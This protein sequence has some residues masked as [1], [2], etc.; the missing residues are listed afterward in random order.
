MANQ[1]G[2]VTPDQEDAASHP[3]RR[4]CHHHEPGTEHHHRHAVLHCDQEDAASLHRTDHHHHVPERD[5]LDHQAEQHPGAMP[6]QTRQPR[7]IP[8]AVARSVDIILLAS[9]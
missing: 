2:D 9:I 1:Q 5:H 8:L 3:S 4:G 7:T 6:T